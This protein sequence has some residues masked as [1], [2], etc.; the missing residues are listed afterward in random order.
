MNDMMTDI[1]KYVQYET[2]ELLI[3]HKFKCLKS[4]LSAIP[5]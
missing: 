3:Y 1:S 2:L 5:E 4:E